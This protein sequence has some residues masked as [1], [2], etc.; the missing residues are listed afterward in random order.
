MISFS[1]LATGLDTTTL[2]SQL[3]KAE[4]API[5]RLKSKQGLIDSRSR[6]I[7]TLRT[8]LDPTGLSSEEKR[9]LGGR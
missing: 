3:V 1:G 9:E 4:G 5:D 2:I 6:K 7:T 8:R